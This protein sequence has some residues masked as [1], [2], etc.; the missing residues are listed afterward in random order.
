MDKKRLLILASVLVFT[1]F[2]WWLS[3]LLSLGK[4]PL[5]G[6]APRTPDYL[7][8]G[9]HVTHMNKQG[10]KK[11]ELRAENLAH[12]PDQKLARLTRVYLIQYEANGVQVHTSADRALYPDNGSEIF[13][14]QNVHIVRKQD[15][16]VI[17]DIRAK[18][19][20]IVLQPASRQ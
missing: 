9:M 16:R 17:G 15:G 18:T 6:E 20:H 3:T 13:M 14:D 1:G 10:R 5:V 7:I 4:Q 2:F 19:T 11:F 12:Y 8:D